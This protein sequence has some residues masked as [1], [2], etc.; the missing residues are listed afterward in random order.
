MG[1]RPSLQV[2]TQL[3]DTDDARICRGRNAGGV[4]LTARP[5][6]WSRPGISADSDAVARR[7]GGGDA[8]QRSKM[9]RLVT[10]TAGLTLVSAARGQL[11]RSA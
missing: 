3:S 5:W 6:G 7:R 9:R 4:C 1:Q 8:M 11:A 2:Y 10:G